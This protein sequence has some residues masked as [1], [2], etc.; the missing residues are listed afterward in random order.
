MSH[1][2]ESEIPI[3][4]KVSDVS[5]Q[6]TNQEQRALAYHL[7]RAMRKSKRQQ[8][9]KADGTYEVTDCVDCG[10][11]IGE[12]RLRVSIMN[13][14]CIYCATARERKGQR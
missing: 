8:E 1:D 12:Q 5:D 13:T 2:P 4:E 9:E 11:E 7:D 10:D 6:A 14:L 3:S